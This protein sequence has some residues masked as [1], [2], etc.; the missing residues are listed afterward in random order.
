MTYEIKVYKIAA[1]PSETERIKAAFVSKNMQVAADI[2]VSDP[3]VESGKVILYS[4]DGRWIT[5]GSKME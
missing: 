5:L 1:N 2:V 3:C 4:P